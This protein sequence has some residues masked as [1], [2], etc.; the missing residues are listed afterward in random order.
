MKRF[1]TLKMIT[2]EAS[3]S[4]YSKRIIINTER[5]VSLLTGLRM[6]FCDR[7]TT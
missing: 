7:L 5:I 1:A 6:E 3:T 2:T 4:N